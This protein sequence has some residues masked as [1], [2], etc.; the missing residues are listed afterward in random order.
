MTN[1][2]LNQLEALEIQIKTHEGTIR[3]Q[4][5]TIQRLQR[6]VEMSTSGRAYTLNLLL[7]ISKANKG[8]RRLKKC[9]ITVA[10]ASDATHGIHRSCS[11]GDSPVPLEIIPGCCTFSDASSGSAQS[12]GVM[13]WEVGA[14][15]RVSP[16]VRFGL[17]RKAPAKDCPPPSCVAA[18]GGGLRGVSVIGI[19]SG[20][21]RVLKTR[22]APS[23]TAWVLYAPEVRLVL[24]ASI[25][26][27]RLKHSAHSS[28][29]DATRHMPWISMV[30]IHPHQR[31]V[32]LQRQKCVMEISMVVFMASW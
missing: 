28:E 5:E 22:R 19:T 29:R 12:A 25:S 13:L 14:G 16:L 11:M 30:I 15:G 3:I 18:P 23:P 7:E 2:E 9:E 24:R 17:S 10:P 27:L 4:N 20:A 8:I 31:Q 1:E 32:M 6:Q 21:V 26:S